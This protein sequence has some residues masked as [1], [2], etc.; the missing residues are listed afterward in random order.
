MS[1]YIVSDIH[2][3]LKALC[4]LLKRVDFHYDGSDQLYILGDYVDWGPNSIETL[5]FCMKLSR[6]PFV[7][8]LMGNHDL[9]FY[10]QILR[11]DCG[12]INNNDLN[13]LYNNR[14]F[15]TWEQ[16]LELTEEEQLEVRD[17]LGSLDY[18]AE[19]SMNGKWYLL[20]HAGPFLP[21]EEDS[22]EPSELERKQFE[23]VW[24]RITGPNS[25]PLR[26]LKK[27]TKSIWEP[28]NYSKFICG[29][30]ITYHYKRFEGNDP[31]TVFFGR[32]FIDIDCGAKCL[33]LDLRQDSIPDETM[34]QC[35]LAMLRLDDMEVFYCDR[36]MAGYLLPGTEE[37]DGYAD[38]IN[39]QRPD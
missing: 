29:H 30:S 20:G 13:W 31:Y 9:M 8:C 36:S 14:G 32:Y 28:R 11:S 24:F 38:N 15:A 21:E 16:F 39:S 4:A 19:V 2:G 17:W 34:L 3:N 5:I 1:T 27:Y 18:S 12:K 25:D 6:E 22:I 35:R 7:K 23:A 37:D 33:G 10:N 26:Q